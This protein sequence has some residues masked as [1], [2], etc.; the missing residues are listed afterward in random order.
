MQWLIIDQCFPVTISFSP[1]LCFKLQCNTGSQHWNSRYWITQHG[2]SLITFKS[3]LFH[4]KQ[5]LTWAQKLRYSGSTLQKEGS[6]TR[7]LQCMDTE[8][9]WICSRLPLFVIGLLP[10]SIQLPTLRK[11]H[12][13]QPCV[14]NVITRFRWVL[15]FLLTMPPTIIIVFCQRQLSQ[16]FAI[17]DFWPNY[18]PGPKDAIDSCN[19][20]SRSKCAFECLLRQLCIYFS[21]YATGGM[22]YFYSF[23]SRKIFYDYDCTCTLMMVS[24]HK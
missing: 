19:A 21:Y 23:V 17:A 8:E 7:W 6:I 12:P 2:I 16:N 5:N 20:T 14:L 18:C 4:D 22:C 15:G 3:P 13:T 11:R 24:F 1:V 10:V 9:R